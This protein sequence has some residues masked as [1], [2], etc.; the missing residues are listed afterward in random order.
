MCTNRMGQS[1]TY[2]M[3]GF[4]TSIGLPTLL[5][6]NS[7]FGLC[8]LVL[9]H[10]RVGESSDAFRSPRTEYRLSNRRQSSIRCQCV[11]SKY[12]TFGRRTGQ[13][14]VTYSSQHCSRP[15]LQPSVRT[16]NSAYYNAWYSTIRRPCSH[17]RR[18][19]LQQYDDFIRA[20]TGAI[21]NVEADQLTGHSVRNEGSV[22]SRR[23]LPLTSIDELGKCS[24][25]RLT[26]I[27][28]RLW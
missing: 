16:A 27:W 2:I 28:Y 8:Y 26:G 7:G 1:H 20:A 3:P 11:R 13:S 10:V 14:S 23:W 12:A 15:A 17:M 6:Y 18:R 5:L 25:D 24:T 19:D 9:E 4:P 21:A 22:W